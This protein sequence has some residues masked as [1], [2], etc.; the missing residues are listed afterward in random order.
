MDEQYKRPITFASLFGAFLI[1]MGI[2]GLFG[3]VEAKEGWEAFLKFSL[4]LNMVFG[5]LL[6]NK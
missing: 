6:I 4:I 5:L 1:L 3:G 2:Y